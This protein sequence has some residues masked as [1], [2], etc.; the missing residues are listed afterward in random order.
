MARWNITRIGDAQ[1]FLRSPVEALVFH[2]GPD[3]ITGDSWSSLPAQAEPY[4]FAD[5]HAWAPRLGAEACRDGRDAPEPEEV[6]VPPTPAERAAAA[7]KAHGDALRRQAAAPAAAVVA[8]RG[9][10]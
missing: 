6:I 10:S 2:E 1:P 4:S 3:T 8:E 9:K 7:R 5:A